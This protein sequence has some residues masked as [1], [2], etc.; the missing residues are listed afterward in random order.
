MSRARDIVTRAT[1]LVE[2]VTALLATQTVTHIVN[3]A[4]AV[5]AEDYVKRAADALVAGLSSVN[6]WLDE[7]LR[8]PLRDLG[9]LRGLLR[10]IS[11]LV[12]GVGD[13]FDAI[14]DGTAAAMGLDGVLVATDALSKAV[15]TG[16]KAV[17]AGATFL[18]G[19][20]TELDLDRLMA[21]FTAMMATLRAW[22]T[23]VLEGVDAVAA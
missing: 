3:A 4:K 14:G 22:T 2:A 5:G 21:A 11:P 9:V 16:R 23:E 13:L 7:N 12:R 6:D 17:D 15:Q 10:L 1:A 18:E 8:A 20:P 19:M